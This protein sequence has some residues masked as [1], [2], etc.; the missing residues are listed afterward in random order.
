MPSAQ[1]EEPS[2]PGVVQTG[3][4]TDSS[5]EALTFQDARLESAPQLTSPYVKPIHF[6]VD[7]GE[8]DEAAQSSPDDSSFDG[9]SSDNVT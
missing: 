9:G 3:T 2:T 1:S 7:V 6:V 4:Q 5:I 8:L